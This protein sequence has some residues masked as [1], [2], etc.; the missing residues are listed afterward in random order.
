MKK[1]LL[2]FTVI[3][4]FSLGTFAQTWLP[5][6][7]NFASGQGVGQISIGMNNPDALWALAINAAGN[8]V[9]A[10]TKSTDGG[11]T[12]TDGTFSAGTGLSQLFAIDENTCFA[13]FNTGASQGIYKTTNG[14]TS[15]AKQ[16]TA[17]GSSSFA[18]ALH[19]FDINHGVAVGDPVAGEF[20]IY[21]TSDGG[22][23]W[24][25]VP[26]ANIPNPSSTGE[27]GITGDISGFGSKFVWFG[28]NEG[29][30]FRSTDKG[31]TWAVT[32][33]P[34]GNVEVIAPEFADSVNGI[35]YRS[36][37]NMGIEPTLNIT[38]DGG[39]TF[40]SVDVSGT[41]YAR[42]FSH[43][44]GTHTYVGSSAD[45]TN[46]MGISVSSDG[47]HNWSVITA[48]SG[49]LAN[50]WVNGTTGW[51]GAY[52][53]TKSPMSTGGMY[54]YNGAGFSPPTVD[55]SASSTAIA[56]GGSVDFT[57]S[58]TGATTYLWTFENAIPPTSTNPNPTGVTWNFPGTYDVTLA[59]T[60]TFGTTT[61]TKTNYIYV[62]GVGV[63]EQKTGGISIFPNPVKDA[64]TIQSASDISE[65]QLIN[66]AGQVVLRQQVNAKSATVNT[67]GL[68]SGVYN[69]KAVTGNSTINKKI[70]IE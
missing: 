64:M 20:E 42:F 2:T 59:A 68:S 54:I 14:G 44:P 31:L 52:A 8:I 38:T 29:R 43:I 13:V 46:G 12:W 63:D 17:F 61:L 69:L 57:N 7:S 32:L 66:I 28:T 22:T 55:F 65:I 26:G 5:V 45:A 15:W 6:N 9:D 11:L 4:G 41:M 39:V 62:G 56:L 16:G 10:Y 33:T 23:T 27:Y 67:S 30:I 48:D 3:L 60:G 70:V 58:C 37:L 25:V 21:T 36:Y 1:A 49:F 50:A 47:G 35:A 34:F 18:D 53:T 40:N 19:F 24:N 51:A